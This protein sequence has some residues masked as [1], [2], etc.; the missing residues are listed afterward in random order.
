VAERPD[1]EVEVALVHRPR[2]NDWS[3]PKGKAETDEH[4]LACALR[5]V[6]EETGYDARAGRHLGTSRYLAWIWL[7]SST[8][9][10]TAFS[11]GFR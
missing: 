8:Q 10:T 2:Y 1:G 11:G 6:Q 3:L 7:F 5:E 9:S 4:L